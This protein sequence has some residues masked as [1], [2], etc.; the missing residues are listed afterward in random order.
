MRYGLIG[1][2]LFHIVIFGVVIFNFTSSR[3]VEVVPPPVPVSVEIMSPKDY[4]ERQAGK[5]DGTAEKPIAP[6]ELK[7][8]DAAASAKKDVEPKQPTPK[9][10]EKEALLP[11]P[12]A[13]E[14]AAAPP[15]PVE[16]AKA[17]PPVEKPVEKPVVKPVVKKA[18]TESSGEAQAQAGA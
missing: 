13:P 2:I 12:P 15:K 10:A 3:K 6:A 8:A 9:P 7:A 1:S 17:E 18:G 4:S 16:V 11:P 5:V 14:P